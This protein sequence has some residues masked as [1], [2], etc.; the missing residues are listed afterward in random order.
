M[1]IIVDGRSLTRDDVVRVARDGEAVVLEDGARRRMEQARAVVERS[2]ARGDAVYG[3]TTGVGVQK[4]FSVSPA[5]EAWFNRR[6]IDNH[7][8][9]V[10]P[11]APPRRCG[12][13]CSA[14]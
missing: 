6:L 3:L 11:P 12:R 8:I 10:G 4:R 9:G 7:R 2:V 14:C 1:T 13:P 5:D